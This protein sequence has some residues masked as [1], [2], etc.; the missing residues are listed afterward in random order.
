MFLIRI[1]V[2]SDSAS[3]S[4]SRFNP[5]NQVYVFNN[6]TFQKYYRPTDGFNPLN[7][8]YVF[9]IK[10]NSRKYLWKW[11]TGFNPLNQVYVFNYLDNQKYT[12]EFLPDGF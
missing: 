6:K 12:M 8:V 10:N 1:L 7:Q 5:L 11:A 4:A 9:N 2:H 3:R